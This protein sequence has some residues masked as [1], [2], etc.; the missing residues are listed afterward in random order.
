MNM[1]VTAEAP[2]GEDMVELMSETMSGLSEILCWLNA[3]HADAATDAAKAKIDADR[4][5]V[6]VAF[7]IAAEL[8]GLNTPKIY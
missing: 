7:H 6:K 1:H 8:A 4:A 3:G 5:A 2:T